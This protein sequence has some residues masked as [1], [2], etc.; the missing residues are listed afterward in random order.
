MD[1]DELICVKCGKHPS[2]I[3]EYVEAAQEEPE[4]FKD[5]A[6]FCWREEGTMNRE[7]GHF[8]CTNCYIDAGMPSSPRGWV[9]P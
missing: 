6:D 7:N 4:Y 9:A 2:Q 8:L 3:A 5:A 1:D